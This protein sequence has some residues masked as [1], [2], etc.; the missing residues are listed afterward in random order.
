ML[1]KLL[2]V[3]TEMISFELTADEKPAELAATKTRNPR[4]Q[5]EYSDTNASRRTKKYEQ[6]KNRQKKYAQ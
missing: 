5:K 3:H 4:L 6:G 2:C 1:T